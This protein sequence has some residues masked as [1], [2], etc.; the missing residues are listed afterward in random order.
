MLR[1]TLKC[2]A[3]LQPKKPYSDTLL[4]LHTKQIS[5]PAFS[6]SLVS[7]RY[8]G[9]P[10]ILQACPARSCFRAFVRTVPSSWNTPLSCTPMSCSI[11]SLGQI[12]PPQKGHPGQPYAKNS[13]DCQFS[14]PSYSILYLFMIL[15]SNGNYIVYVYLLNFI[16]CTRM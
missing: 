8:N 10:A 9:L 7:S 16:I 2:Q 1:I 4:P 14:L 3:L 11:P 6:Q 12:A 13:A 5:S 15:I